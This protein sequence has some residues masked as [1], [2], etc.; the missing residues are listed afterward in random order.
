HAAATLQGNEIHVRRVSLP[1]LKRSEILPALALECRKHVSF[2]IEDAEIRYEVLGRTAAAAGGG[3][4]LLVAVAH[5]SAIEETR[6]AM[7]EAGLNPVALTVRPIGLRALLRS[8]KRTE[9]DAVVAYL[10]LGERQ[11]QIIVLR[12]DEIR[13]TREFEIGG[14]T[15]TDALRSIVVPGQGTIEL[16]AQD[17]EQL[18]RTSGIPFGEEESGAAGPI[19]LSAVSVMLRPVLE[20]LVRE[21][22]NSFDYCNEQFLGEAVTRVVVHGEASQVR[23]LPAYLSG[24]LELSVEWADLSQEALALSPRPASGS[25][26]GG[27][28]SELA[29]GLCLLG[30]GSLNFL[31]P[32]TT[33]VSYRIAEAIPQRI[34]IGVAAMLLLSVS[35]PAQVSVMRERQEV[36]RLQSV[37]ISLEPR[38]DALRRFRAAREEE[39]RLQ[40]LLARLSG[41]Q[42]LWSYV[43]RDLSHRIGPNAR[44]TAI[45]VVDPVP[46]ANSAPQGTEPPRRRL[47]L[48]GLLQTG[49]ERPEKGLGE[50]MQVLA[51]SRVVQQVQL[52]GCQAVSPSL[53]SFTL[54]A[55]L[56]E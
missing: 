8:I 12:G 43:L 13:F 36:G 17:A 15:L 1:F 20:R 18:K 23:N 3:L 42:V 39:T 16:T 48:T 24:I 5:R 4:Q 11:S 7:T 47:R 31:E 25:S 52:E 10:E 14:A 34:A 56:A 30:R 37:L 44:L 26:V 35:L 29:V 9:S 50:L 45:E 40:D 22:L 28:P 53:S 38:T 46:A 27:R 55:V 33:G 6:T 54:T 19:P 51:Q 21:L 2:P 49:A 32:A 41:G